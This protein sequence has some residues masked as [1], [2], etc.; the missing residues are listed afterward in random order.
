MRV[1]ARPRVL[2]KG[3]RHEGGDQLLTQGHLLDDRTSCHNVVGRAHRVHRTQVDL[4]L[5]GASLV[6]RELDGNPHV[7]Q[8]AHRASPEIIRVPARNVIEIARLIDGHHALR[9]DGLTQQ[10]ELDLGVHHDAEAR[11]GGALDNALENAARIRGRWAAI[12]H[13]DVAEHTSDRI[14]VGTPRQQLK[15]RGIGHEQHIGLK[16]A[17]EALD[18]RAVET[19]ALSESV[20]QLAWVNRNRLQDASDV[21]KPQPD[22]TDVLLRDLAQHVL[23]MRIHRCPPLE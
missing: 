23:L 16:H 17:G 11:V 18:S 13:E 20:L 2:N 15:G 6:M 3:L 9:G 1:H 4:I 8:H 5:A 22:E 7:L 14:L 19:D 21:R 12:G 10:V